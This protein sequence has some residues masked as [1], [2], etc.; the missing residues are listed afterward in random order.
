[1]SQPKRRSVL[2]PVATVGGCI[3]FMGVVL[4]GCDDPAD[5]AAVKQSAKSV[6]ESQRL[7]RGARQQVN[8]TAEEIDEAYELG[9]GMAQ[10]QRLAR[11]VVDRL[12]GQTDR[13]VLKK[14]LAEIDALSQERD[15]SDIESLRA[16][17]DRLGQAQRQ[18]SADEEK[19]RQANV[20][21]NRERLEKG[22]KILRQAIEAARQANEKHGEVGPELLLGTLYLSEAR[23]VREQLQREELEI[24]A[25]QIGLQRGA[26]ELLDEQGRIFE[27]EAA[28]PQQN[29]AMLKAQLEGGAGL[30]GGGKGLRE[31]LAQAEQQIEQL[32][33][34]QRQLQEEFNRKSEQATDLHRKYLDTLDEAEKF[35]GEKRYELQEQ[36]YTLRLGKGMGAGDSGIDYEAQ[37]ELTRSRLAMVESALAFGELRRDQLTGTIV[38]IEKR[39]EQLENSP[40]A[41]AENAKRFEEHATNKAKL[42]ATFA[43]HLDEVKNSEARY[44]QLRVETIGAYNEA[45]S[46][47]GR[48]GR[49][50]GPRSKTGDYAKDLE[51]LARVE[52]SGLWLSDA[53][54]YERA[55]SLLGLVA[56]FHGIDQSV[57]ELRESYEKQ[58]EQA[59]VSAG[60][61]AEKMSD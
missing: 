23:S 1:M 5:T 58:A 9:D 56:S 19:I 20:E 12:E 41:R 10:Y 26:S 61:L 40:E 45:V 32:A 17:S 36:A 30:T 48:A 8:L 22:K 50:A 11:R 6:N 42:L 33:E 47:F 24:Q 3:F 49:A 14:L 52:L 28:H 13:A 4:F 16:I 55:S 59:R 53:L 54:Q 15:D 37:T 18:F 21:I 38:Q 31:Q 25:F 39:I 27:I 34:Q 46:A 35:R 7:L 44:V 57:S 51:G 60:D 43:G 29:I 2:L